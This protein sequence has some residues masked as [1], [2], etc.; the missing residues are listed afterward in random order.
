MN[1][2]TSTIQRLETALFCYMFSFWSFED[3]E[4][5]FGYPNVVVNGPEFV[6]VL[7]YLGRAVGSVIR[8]RSWLEY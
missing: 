6:D 7:I 5:L 3:E 8:I 2:A 4:G 1:A